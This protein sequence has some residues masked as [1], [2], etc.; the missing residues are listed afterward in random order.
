MG[1]RAELIGSD[2][3]WG[4]VAVL[5]DD[6]NLVVGLPEHL[7]RQAQLLDGVEAPDP[8]AG[9]PSAPE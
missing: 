9:L 2:L 4:S 1:I 5:L 6:T 3:G 8:R 7:E